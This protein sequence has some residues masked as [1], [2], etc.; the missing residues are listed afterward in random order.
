MKKQVENTGKSNEQ[1]TVR[2]NETSSLFASQFILNTS[3]DDVTISFSSGPLADPS[4]N[5]TIL[6]VHSRIA[7]TRDGAKRLYEILGSVL[8]QNKSGPAN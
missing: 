7:M 6:P 3:S 2:Y 5:G 1:V 4:G 8:A